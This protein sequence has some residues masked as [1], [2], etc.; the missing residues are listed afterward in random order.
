MKT[1]IALVLAFAGLAATAVALQE[2]T[3]NPPTSPTGEAA[4]APKGI[5]VPNMAVVKTETL[6]GGLIIEDLK[7]GDGYEVKPGG[8]VVALYHG[9]RK[10]DGFV[11]DSAF[12]RGEPIGFSLNGVITGWQKGVPGMKVGGVRRLTIPA[13]MGYGERGAGAD[14][15]PNTDLVFVI[16]I[17][18]AVQIEDTKEGTGEVASGSFVA[19]TAHT[20]KDKDGKEVEKH[21][22]AN[23]YIW[24]PGEMQGFQYGMEGMKVGGERT[25]KV[26]KEFNPAVPGSPANRPG[27]QA[28]SIDVKLIALR[29][30]QQQGG[31]RR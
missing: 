25:I 21:D 11:F 22:A 3:T 5:P 29:N 19:V 12:E 17:T 30:L 13:V 6:E 20:I 4:P 9:T 16:E 27:G 2:T 24:I 15:P 1:A 28:L 23:P 7:I 18:D 8:A 31:R 26:P 10:S 14:I